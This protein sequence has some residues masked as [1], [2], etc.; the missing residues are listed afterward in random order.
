[1]KNEAG[2]DHGFLIASGEYAVS[3]SP[4]EKGFKIYLPKM[5]PEETL[6]PMGLA[7]TACFIRLDKDEDFRNECIAWFMKQKQ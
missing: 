1:M 7:L 2:T 6:D 3:Y 4:S 5:K